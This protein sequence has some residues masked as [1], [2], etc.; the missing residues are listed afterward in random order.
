M[1]K[2]LDNA[3]FAEHAQRRLAAFG[4]YDGKIDGWA[5]AKT[6]AAFD[7]ALNTASAASNP[8]IQSMPWPEP[9]ERSLRAFYGEPGEGNLVT[10]SLP[11]PMVLAWDHSTTVTRT[12]C[13]RLVARSLT[14]RL[15]AIRDHC[16]P[17]GLIDA[18]MHLFGGVYNYRQQ[19][20][21]QAL[22]L[23]AWGAAIDL[24]PKHNAFRSPWPAEATMPLDVI[25]IFEADG[26]KSG[27]RAWGRDAM[28]FQATR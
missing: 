23:H 6:R 8:T 7:L 2:D 16:G 18:R 27:A 15:E 19:R 1:P 9:D 3:D 5:G 11:Y 21:G 20:G 10:I 12:R 26:W 4:S 24:D 17:G 14:G 25:R 22:S 28:H 13:H